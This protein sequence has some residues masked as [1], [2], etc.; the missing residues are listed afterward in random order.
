ME[1]LNKKFEST[2]KQKVND[3][4]I[5]LQEEFINWQKSRP[6]IEI[7]KLKKHVFEK[8][9]NQLLRNVIFILPDGQ[10]IKLGQYIPGKKGFGW[11]GEDSEPL[12]FKKVSDIPLLLYKLKSEKNK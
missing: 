12:N 6:K 8:Y 4:F 7:D 3:E 2:E 5:D 10:E 11:F 9:D 1:N